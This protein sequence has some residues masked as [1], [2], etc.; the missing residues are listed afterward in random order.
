[1]GKPLTELCRGKWWWWCSGGG[2]GGGGGFGEHRC[3]DLSQTG[4]FA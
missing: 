1:M 3:Y 2:G 4:Q